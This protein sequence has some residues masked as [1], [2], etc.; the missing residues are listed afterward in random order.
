MNTGSKSSSKS[1]SRGPVAKP[2]SKSA[3]N[4]SANVNAQMTLPT[5][6]VEKK[7]AKSSKAVKVALNLQLHDLI[8]QQASSFAAR[9]HRNQLRRDG[10]TPYYT[11]VVRV[12]FT[13]ALVFNC[14]DETA[15]ATALL[16]DTIEDTT[17]DYED[18]S[19]RFGDDVAE[20]VAALTKNMALPEEEREQT[21]DAKLTA[22]PWQAKLVKLADAFDNLHDVANFPADRR[23]EQRY[24][25]VER[26][27][28]AVEIARSEPK[29]AVLMNACKIVMGLY[30]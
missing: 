21:Y 7:Q 18:I 13:V 5:S 24:K 1:V 11:H 17:T 4:T 16:H 8:W 3:A 6:K 14:T 15:I 12:A 9:A 20:C 28:R 2:G 26:C 29:N 30:A 25:A 10:R 22:S 23:D 19:E 27:R